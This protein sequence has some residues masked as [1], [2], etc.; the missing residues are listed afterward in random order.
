MPSTR[1]INRMASDG[2]SFEV[3]GKG[4]EQYSRAVPRSGHR[5]ILHAHVV[6]R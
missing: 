3:T 2:L 1:A 6:L 5:Q 4:P